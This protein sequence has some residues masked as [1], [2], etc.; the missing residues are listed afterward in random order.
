M[1]SYSDE[2]SCDHQGEK[3]QTLSGFANR[4]SQG[5]LDLAIGLFRIPHAHFNVVDCIAQSKLAETVK[6]LLSSA[7][8]VSF[9]RKA[10]FRENFN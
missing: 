7:L 5:L 6:S 3:A 9:D 4:F 2:L 1:S 10:S 8:H